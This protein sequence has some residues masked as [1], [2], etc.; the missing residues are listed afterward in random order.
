MC[1]LQTKW[2][3][4]FQQNLKVINKCL[5]LKQLFIVTGYDFS[6]QNYIS[7]GN[8]YIYIFIKQEPTGG[9]G[10]VA[11]NSVGEN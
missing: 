5:V 4:K 6:L 2:K 7:H 3:R 11:L 1:N 8:I 10:G 9:R